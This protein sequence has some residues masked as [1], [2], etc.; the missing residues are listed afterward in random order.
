MRGRGLMPGPQAA[1]AQSPSPATRPTV[2][3]RLS[4][5]I[6]LDLLSI[7]AIALVYLLKLSTDYSRGW[8]LTWLALVCIII[9]ASRSAAGP[10]LTW[11]A[12]TGRAVRRICVVYSGAAGPLSS[13]VL[14]GISG[15]AVTGL[16]ELD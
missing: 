14:R 4:P 6:V 3:V 7:S 12:T 8:M 11:L 5:K 1:V 10:F 16:Y 2:S 13:E 15:V 9:P